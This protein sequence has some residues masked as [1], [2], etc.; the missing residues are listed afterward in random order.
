MNLN[1]TNLVANIDAKFANTLILLLM[2]SLIIRQ[3]SQ[4]IMTDSANGV[5]LIHCKK[6][7]ET[8]Y[9]GETGG[10]FIYRFND[11]THYQ[12]ENASSSAIALQCR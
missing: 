1:A 4:A 6:C 3:L 12:T 9:I 5:Y 2:F 7:P 10:N 11:H 8:L